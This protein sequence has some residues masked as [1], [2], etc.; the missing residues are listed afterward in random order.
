MDRVVYVISDPNDEN[1]GSH[2]HTTPDAFAA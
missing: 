2:T 1:V